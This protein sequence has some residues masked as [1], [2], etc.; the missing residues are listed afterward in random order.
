MREKTESRYKTNPRQQ[1]LLVELLK[2]PD[3]QAASRAAGIG[4]T[5]AYRWLEDSAFAAELSRLRNDTLKEALDSVKSLTSRAAAELLRLLDTP[6]E[7][8][9]RLLCNDILSHA[10]KVRELEQIERRLLQLEEKIN[11]PM[12]GTL[13]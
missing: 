4:R 6:D 10:I 11:R 5:T 3:I 12:K 1:K 8:L 13:Q 2:N 7:R 9:R